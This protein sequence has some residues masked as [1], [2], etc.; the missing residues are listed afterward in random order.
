MPISLKSTP[1]FITADMKKLIAL[2]ISFSL[3]LTSCIA[4]RDESDNKG[5]LPLNTQSTSSDVTDTKVPTEAADTTTSKPAE[6]K[7]PEELPSL[8]GFYDELTSGGVYTRLDTWQSP[9][10]EG[11]DIA[12]FDIVLS[13]EKTLSSTSYKELWKAEAS[14]CSVYPAAKPYLELRYKLSDG[15]ENFSV[16]RTPADAEAVAADGYLEVYL[17]DDVHQEDGAW[18]SHLT[19]YTVTADTVISS[20]KLTSGAKIG[21][22]TEISLSA[23][24]DG[25]SKAIILI[26]KG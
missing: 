23:C 14:K 15:S 12:V 10:I 13:S 18:Y 9:W 24:I 2:F 17:Y 21:E 22:V 19:D 6:T 1:C 20:V 16:I 25:S 3:L 7:E 8:I 26:Y 5:T 4:L 11:T